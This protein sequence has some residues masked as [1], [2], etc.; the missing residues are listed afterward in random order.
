MIGDRK[1]DI[2]S[3][4]NAGTKTVLVKTANVPVEVPEATYTA[5]NL[6]DAVTYVVSHTSTHV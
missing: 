5:P 6:L 2:F 3:G 1:S 4:I